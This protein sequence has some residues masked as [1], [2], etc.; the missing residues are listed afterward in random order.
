MSAE[1]EVGE[2]KDAENPTRID[3]AQ[4]ETILKDPYALLKKMGL[5][6][7]A[8]KDQHPTPSGI[9]MGGWPPYPLGPPYGWPGLFS[10]CYGLAAP[11]TLPMP[12]T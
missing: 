5:G 8:K 9:N 1:D 6:E 4:L 12:S 7:D 11:R 10:P 3:E 2:A